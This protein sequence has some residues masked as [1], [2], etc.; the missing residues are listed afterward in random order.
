MEPESPNDLERRMYGEDTPKSTVDELSN[1]G[2]ETPR[3][4]L[5]RELGIETPKSR[6]ET[7]T[8]KLEKEL[9]VDTPT[10]VTPKSKTN[11]EPETPKPQLHLVPETPRSTFETPKVVIPFPPDTP[12][13]AQPAPNPPPETPKPQFE[14]PTP[15]KRKQGDETPHSKF[16][17]SV[18]QMM[19][20][21]VNIDLITRWAAWNI[22]LLGIF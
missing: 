5:K 19:G 22:W 11:F 8:S 10:F 3:S 1:T 6:F 17:Q 15:R 16:E 13:S 20:D 9:G 7:P 12:A 18:K 21:K 4:K 2:E 14:V